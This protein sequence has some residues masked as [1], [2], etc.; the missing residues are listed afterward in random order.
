VD[1]KEVGMKYFVTTMLVIFVIETIGKAVVLHTKD[2]V[3]NPRAIVAD[4][5]L[6]VLFAVWAAWLLGAA[7]S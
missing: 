1:E 4:L 6:G 5:A 3:R 7:E 2:F